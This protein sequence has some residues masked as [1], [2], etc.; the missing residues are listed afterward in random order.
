[1]S[2]QPRQE[3]LSERN[4]YEIIQVDSWDAFIVKLATRF[5]G[6]QWIFRGQRCAR[7]MLQTRLE[8]VFSTMQP[9]KYAA[10]ESHVLR[11]FRRRLHHYT[12]DVPLAD[13]T[14]EWLALMQHYGAPTRLLDWTRSPYIGLYFA[15]EDCAP[16]VPCAVWAL[17]RRALY[18][19]SMEVHA[20]LFDAILNS[21]LQAVS[22]KNVFNEFVM[23][24]QVLGVLSVEPFR[25]NER[26][27]YQQGLF[28]V[29][30]SVQH[31]FLANLKRQ[32][33][34]PPSATP[35]LRRIEITLSS[36]ARLE[37]L[38]QLRAMN[39]HRATLF[40]GMDGFAQSLSIEA[41]IWGSFD[42]NRIL[43]EGKY[44]EFC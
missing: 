1:M 19:E 13:D 36:R 37:C 23:R 15:I 39:I 38:E 25:M 11:Q 31:S 9:S 8:R 33:L 2:N 4:Q 17:D 28:L 30:T 35:Y 10:A 27:T 40:P 24:G 3:E 7:W 14:I 42:D 43:R 21:P 18:R 41:E 32:T 22:D 34:G 12:S 29:P 16:E 26:I 20:G 44:N 5:R 6:E